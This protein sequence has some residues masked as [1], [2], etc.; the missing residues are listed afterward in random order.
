MGHAIGLATMRLDGFVSMDGYDTPGSVTTK[1]LASNGDRLVLNARAPQAAY[2]AQ[3]QAAAPYGVLRAEVL[4]GDGRVIE[5]YSADDCDSFTG[6]DLRHVVTWRGRPRLPRLDG[7]AFRLRFHLRN[8][9][10]YSFQVA[11]RE[12]GPQDVELA[13][14]GSRGAP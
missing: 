8:A 13:E 7:D 9:A 12:P 6:D 14:P 2:D 10:L 3:P 4:D 5:R 1:P 11:D